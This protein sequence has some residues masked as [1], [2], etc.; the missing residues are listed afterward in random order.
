VISVRLTSKQISLYNAYL[1]AEPERRNNRF[2]ADYYVFNRICTHPYMLIEHEKRA[3]ES[4]EMLRANQEDE[5]AMNNFIDDR[6]VDEIENG[7]DDDS[8]EILGEGTSQQKAGGRRGAGAKVMEI[9][10]RE[11]PPEERGWFHNLDMVTEEDESNFTL[12]NKLILLEQIIRKA[13]EVG[14]KVLVFTWSLE[15][16]RLIAR[17]LAEKSKGWSSDGHVTAMPAGESWGWTPKLDYLVIEG[18]VDVV[19]RHNIQDHFND[20][21]DLRARLLLI[22]T[23]VWLLDWT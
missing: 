19:E 21:N 1:A 12:G 4:E 10:P 7:S 2:L 15:S 17:M 3:K 9:M 23:K 8:V 11:L 6:D 22:S 20:A 5:E 16:L 18:S 13:E 14:D